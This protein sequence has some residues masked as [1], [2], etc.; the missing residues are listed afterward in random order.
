MDKARNYDEN[1]L[2]TGIKLANK[3]IFDKASAGHFAYDPCFVPPEENPPFILWL[4]PS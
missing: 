1:R 4:A 3:S 2:A